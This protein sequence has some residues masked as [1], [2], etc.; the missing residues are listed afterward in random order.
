MRR[1]AL[2]AAAAVALVV[3]AIVYIA[4]SRRGKP[5][6][7]RAMYGGRTPAVGRWPYVVSLKNGECTGFLIDPMHVVTA[8]HCPQ[9]KV[10]T[11]GTRLSIGGMRSDEPADAHRVARVFKVG[12]GPGVSPRDWAILELER[13]SIKRPVL[14]NGL[15]TTVSDAEIFGGDL[16]GAGFGEQPGRKNPPTTLMEASVKVKLARGQDAGMFQIALPGAPRGGCPGDSGAPL[17][18][19]RQGGADVV[20][21]IETGAAGGGPECGPHTTLWT[22][23]KPAMQ[24]MKQAYAVNEARLQQC[25]FAD[26]AANRCPATHPW[27]TGL[28]VQ[29]KQCA[30][31]GQCAVDVFYKYV[32]LGQASGVPFKA[33]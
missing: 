22:P 32:K 29:G 8:G 2:V 9:D 27:D 19:R 20:V 28:Q 6:R 30:A 18:L 33:A 3:A 24:A 14:A 11:P 21:G 1:R 4:A 17:V 12:G 10:G 7:R 26:R 23:V 16:W 15:Q 31:T 5:P 25:A 13:P